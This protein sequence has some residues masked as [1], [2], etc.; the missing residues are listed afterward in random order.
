MDDA[1]SYCLDR[2]LA[3]LSARAEP[4]RFS[5][6]LDG[7]RDLPV[8]LL[9]RLLSREAMRVSATGRAPR[10]DRAEALAERLA[11]ALAGGGSIRSTLGGAL[12]RLDG[13][14]RLTLAP[15]AGRKRGRVDAVRRISPPPDENKAPSLGNR[16]CES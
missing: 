8:E 3:T 16:G 2:S 14:G 6:D 9:T 5:V 7:V 12:V 13:R 11:E 10:L 1:A 15:E 4:G